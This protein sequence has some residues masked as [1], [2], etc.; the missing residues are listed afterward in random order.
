VLTT[1]VTAVF[2]LF[3][4]SL[5]MFAFFVLVL[6]VFVMLAAAMFVVLTAT[7]FTIV[8]EDFGDRVKRLRCLPHGASE[9]M[10]I[11][12]WPPPDEVAAPA[13]RECGP[14]YTSISCS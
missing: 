11:A 10:Q 6:F 3:L 2:V 14:K 12:H 13:T 9:T 4:V 5:F 8:F 1:F 7:V